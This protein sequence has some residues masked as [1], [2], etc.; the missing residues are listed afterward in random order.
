MN[1]HPDSLNISLGNSN[2]SPNNINICHDNLNINP[3]SS[4]ISLG[5]L[6]LCRDSLDIIKSLITGLYYF[7][8]LVIGLDRQ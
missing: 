7:D 4:R 1:L 3:E 2:I 5:G 8:N 6:S